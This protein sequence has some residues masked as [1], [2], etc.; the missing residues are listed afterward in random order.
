MKSAILKVRTKHFIM[1]LGS[2]V[3]FW[4]YHAAHDL[5]EQ[6]RLCFV[7]IMGGIEVANGAITLGN[8]QAFLQYMQQFSQPISGGQLG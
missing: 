3:C 4:D 5:P 7:A 8:V 2:P 1:R 6:H